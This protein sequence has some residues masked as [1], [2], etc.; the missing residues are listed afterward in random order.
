MTQEE[1]W[2]GF[3]EA[4]DRSSPVARDPK[5]TTGNPDT[6]YLYNLKRNE[7]IEYKR[8]IADPKLRALKPTEGDALK[9]LKS[10]FA[11]ALKEFTPRRTRPT[12][13]AVPVAV[14]GKK[15][16]KATVEEDVAEESEDFEES[17]FDEG[18]DEE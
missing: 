8:A 1:L 13:E 2:Y 7:I 18:G 17:F 6:V 14:V 3:L 4:G 9:E 15:K 5:L 10:A 12:L 16:G 11:K